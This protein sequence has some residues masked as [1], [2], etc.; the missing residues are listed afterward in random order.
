VL[1]AATVACVCA[2][3]LFLIPLNARILPDFIWFCGIASL[4]SFLGC[5][6]MQR[7]MKTSVR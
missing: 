3:Y 5:R 2:A 4:V 7:I 1:F 6:A